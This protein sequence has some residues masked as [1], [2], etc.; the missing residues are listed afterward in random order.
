MVAPAIHQ[1]SNNVGAELRGIQLGLNTLE[2][3]YG[4]ENSRFAVVSNCQ[5]AVLRARS[6][7]RV[8]EPSGRPLVPSGLWLQVLIDWIP[9]HSGHPLNDL[10]DQLAADAVKYPDDCPQTNQFAR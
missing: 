1:P 10:A 7:P 5:V 8:P 2:E 4:Y 3:T 9:G 6:T